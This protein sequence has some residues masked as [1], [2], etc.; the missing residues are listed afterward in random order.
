[1]PWVFSSF[2]PGRNRTGFWI[3]F[4]FPAGSKWTIKNG[5]L[6]ELFE[7]KIDRQKVPRAGFGHYP[8]EVRADDFQTRFP[9]DGI[10]DIMVFLGGFTPAPFS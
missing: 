8:L 10:L 6:L 4:I 9:Q 2:S 3:D 1:M 7:N 5:P